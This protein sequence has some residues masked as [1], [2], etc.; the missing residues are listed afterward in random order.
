MKIL[1]NYIGENYLEMEVN[2]SNQTL[3]S[4]V[5]DRSE[6]S[7]IRD[8]LMELVDELEEFLSKKNEPPAK[9]SKLR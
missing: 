1:I 6:S 2:V 3:I 5:F 7:E 9:L 4:S 8:H